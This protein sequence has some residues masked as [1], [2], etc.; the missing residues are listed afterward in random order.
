MAIDDKGDT[1]WGIDAG[2]GRRNVPRKAVFECATNAGFPGGT[3]FEFSLAQNHGGW[4]SDEHMNN[5]LGRFRF[6][7]TTNAGPIV[8]DPVPAPLR[9]I[10]AIPQQDRTLA[11]VATVFHYWRTT[12]SEW[13]DVNEK[14][15]SL[16]G[17]WPVG[18][19]TLTLIA[20]EHG[21]DTHVLKRGDFLQPTK[22]VAP[23]A[24]AFLNPLPPGA[25]PTR[26]TF[27]KWLA[28]RKS[29]TTARAIVNRIWQTYFGIGLVATPEDFG[30]R[31]ETPSH[32]ELLDWL[33]CELMDNGWSLKH[34]HRLIVTSATYRQSSA[35]PPEMY[36]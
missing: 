11:Q 31:S 23:G 34:I 12:V 14:I 17:Q 13:R 18:D 5:N 6:S 30:M 3:I 26:L 35:A 25:P 29:P 7:L 32:P 16:W 10:L 20:R 15:E 19:T 27:G 9:D 2:P 8:A 36:E 24:P 33:A 28:D 1:G 21:R 4:N 22:E